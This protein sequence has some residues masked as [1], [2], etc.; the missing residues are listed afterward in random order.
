VKAYAERTVN[1]Y[2]AML[3]GLQKLA[4]NQN[5][6]FPYEMTAAQQELVSKLQSKSGTDFDKAYMRAEV[7]AQQEMIILLQGAIEKAQTPALKDF[8]TVNLIS[9]RDRADEAQATA[10]KIHA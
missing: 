8:A 9:V 4:Q 7:D 6:T 10:K 2:S 3:N 5:V 1:E